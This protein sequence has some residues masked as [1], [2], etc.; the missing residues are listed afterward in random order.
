[1]ITNKLREKI[2]NE[3]NL[4]KV[5]EKLKPYLGEDWDQEIMQHI[6]EI[7]PNDEIP[8]DS[9]SYIRKIK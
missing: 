4:D 6:Q 9:F 3:Q 8:I 2:L 7:T 5:L 1:M